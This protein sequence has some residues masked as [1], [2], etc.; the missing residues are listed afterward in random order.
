MA[1]TIQTLYI[2]LD[3]RIAKL[4]GSLN[5]GRAEVRKFAGET[6]TSMRET[7][8]AIR[9]LGDEVGVHL[10]FALEQ[11]I[12]RMGGV[13]SLVAKAFNSIAVVGFG[14]VAI[15]TGKKIYEF[16]KQ[17][18]EQ[19]RKFQEGLSNLHASLQQTNDQALV[20]NDRLRNDIA[21]LEGKPQNNL[22]LALHESWVEADRLSAK[23]EEDIQ[24][25]ANLFQEG[26]VSKWTS[27]FTDRPETE[28]VAA[29]V[30]E[31]ADAEKGME[32]QI[33]EMLH[34][35]GP[36]DVKADEERAHA[37]RWNFYNDK[38]LQAEQMQRDTQA[39]QY[40]EQHNL[41]A[42]GQP[43]AVLAWNPERYKR[44][45][46]PLAQ[47]AQLHADLLLQRDYAANVGETPFL[48]ARKDELTKG[49][50]NGGGG[51]DKAAADRLHQL[52]TQIKDQLAKAARDQ[53]LERDGLLMVERNFWAQY[54]DTFAKGSAQWQTVNDAFLDKDT[55]ISQ[56]MNELHRKTAD[57]MDKFFTELPR[58]LVKPLEMQFSAQQDVTEVQRRH[59]IEQAKLN[60]DLAT[61]EIHWQTQTGGLSQ[62][63]ALH[64]EIAAQDKQWADQLVVLNKELADLE[65]L[66]LIK[67][68][69]QKSVEE[70][71]D[72]IETMRTEFQRTRQ[73]LAR[74]LE[75][76]D[77]SHSF[78]GLLRAAADVNLRLRDEFIRG[79]DSINRA[80]AQTIA[81]AGQ[82]GFSA[83]KI[84]GG[85]FQSMAGDVAKIGIEGLEGSLLKS[86]GFGSKKAPTGAAGDPVHTVDD[87]GK[88]G[89]TGP[90]NPF[91]SIAHWIGGLFH[92]H[93]GGFQ[94]S[95]IA[96]TNVAG[97]LGTLPSDMT[98]SMGN[99]AGLFGS[100]GPLSEVLGLPANF[101]KAL[102]GGL[103][104]LSSIGSI[105][106]AFGGFLAE[107]GPIS[108][109]H[110]YVA[111]EKGPE[112]IG[113]VNGRVFN[114]RGGTSMPMGQ[115]AFYYIDARDA[116]ASEV[117]ARVRYG[118][119]QV[120]G[121]AVAASYATAQE[122]AR[123]RPLSMPA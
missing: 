33:A 83:S 12:A 104:I 102:G 43:D 105:F 19:A 61:R 80:I 94:P 34:A 38:L 114:T 44:W 2:D 97:V 10:P 112:I 111:G 121:S 59:A 73:D 27:Y 51:A 49:A 28:D 119:A 1:K 78:D 16:F 8:E 50:G 11:F 92:R 58:S 14:M 86:L 9:L 15:E 7:R 39:R 36:H 31:W 100:G 66:A 30:A 108:S 79:I 106:S 109:H 75:S 41:T 4:E 81:T 21:R 87:T 98:S 118:L 96:P 74:Q 76:E 37:I 52:Q 62:A 88:A 63:A 54:L 53:Q 65:N 120:H 42:S 84:F 89:A 123:R 71:K 70:M 69:A 67:P 115:G 99:L 26:A 93:G 6:K 40:R 82:Q 47:L 13:G 110:W 113:G 116:N 23:L 17:A 103:G 46:E 29:K 18:E 32:A 45:N 90:A 3:A 68:E 22:A 77:W 20:T 72:K 60:A 107:G 5:K 25:T 48:Q 35:T 122:A 56:R 85:M 64:G 24:K 101:G 91:T 95:D 55:A 117:D 57:Q